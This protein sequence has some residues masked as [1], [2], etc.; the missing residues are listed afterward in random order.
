MKFYEIYFR[1]KDWVVYCGDVASEDLAMEEV[2][3]L[4][5]EFP[6]NQYWYEEVIAGD[7]EDE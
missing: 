2:R 3:I 7:D 4:S 5:L 6:D 1:S